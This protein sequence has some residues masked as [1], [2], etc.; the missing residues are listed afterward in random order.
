MLIRDFDQNTDVE[1]LQSCIVELQDSSRLFDDRMPAGADIVDEYIPYMLDKC[2][3][4]DGKILVGVVNDELVGYAAILTKVVCD[5]L[6]DRGIEY[7]LVYDLAVLQKYR[8]RGY[9]RSLLEAAEAH[10]RASSV[11]W[12]RIGLLGDNLVA[13]KLYLS[14]GFSSQYTEL[15]KDLARSR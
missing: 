1:Q 8:Q 4:Y 5:A 10:A 9:G 7:G 3:K 2:E 13:G 12:L 15:E 11:R 6:E 14:M